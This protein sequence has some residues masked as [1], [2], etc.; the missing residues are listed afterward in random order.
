MN[1]Y[2]DLLAYFGIG[3]AHPGGASLTRSIF[4]KVSINQDDLVLDIGC[5]TGQTAQ[6]LAKQFKCS[7]TAIDH[8]PLMVEKA[9]RRFA[10]ENLPVQVIIGN[11]EKLDIESQTFNFIL[12][13]SVISFTHAKE[14]IKELA[15]VLKEKGQLLL[16]EMA[17]EASIPKSMKEEVQRLYGIH[18]IYTGEEWRSILEE[19][20]FATIEEIQTHSSLISSELNEMDLSESIPMSLYDVWD[21][22]N[23]MTEKVHGHIGYIVYLAS[24]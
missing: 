21:E 14:T 23:E 22:H 4:E 19:A 16:I 18:D 3:S 12:S 5:G 24:K 11:A 7:V 13:E 17:A 6:Y 1:E 2:I 10:K 15:R 20:G 9:K 8:H